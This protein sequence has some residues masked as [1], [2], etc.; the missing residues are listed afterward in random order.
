MAYE[1]H[2]EDDGDDS[3]NNDTGP[4]SWI[5]GHQKSDG[6]FHCVYGNSPNPQRNCSALLNSTS[7]G[8][9]WE[10]TCCDVMRRE[11]EWSDPPLIYCVAAPQQQPLGGHEHS[12]VTNNLTSSHCSV[13]GTDRLS[14]EG[15]SLKMDHK[16]VETVV[17]FFALAS[18]LGNLGVVTHCVVLNRRRR[19]RAGSSAKVGGGERV[20]C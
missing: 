12:T 7:S 5:G 15:N 4:V 14:V 20:W 2:H 17:W 18:V 13:D 11:A 6:S 19:N 1:N 16:L 10:H 8:H 3:N 9:T